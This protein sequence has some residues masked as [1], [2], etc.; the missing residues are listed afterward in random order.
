MS[1]GAKCTFPPGAGL[2]L[3]YHIAWGFSRKIV[4]AFIFG[5]ELL[6]S[7]TSTSQRANVHA[8]AR[9]FIYP[10]VFL[11]LAHSFAPRELPNSL[12]INLLHTFYG[13]GGVHS[14]SL[15]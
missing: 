11:L 5:F 12:R 1:L 13:R 4:L 10:L 3:C 6:N 14:P 9:V 2:N 15:I 8:D 7:F